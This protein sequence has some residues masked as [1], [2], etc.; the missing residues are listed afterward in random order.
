MDFQTS[1]TKGRRQL[2][3]PYWEVPGGPVFKTPWFHCRGC[4]FGP[5]SGN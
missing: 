1:G 2:E 4:R 3:L 5:W